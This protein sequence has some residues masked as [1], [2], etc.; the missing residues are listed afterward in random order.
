MTGSVGSQL[1]DDV[2]D[3]GR[4]DMGCVGRSGRPSCPSAVVS[5]ATRVLEREDGEAG[6]TTRVEAKTP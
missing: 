4:W 5:S 3:E 6:M 1:A 2:G